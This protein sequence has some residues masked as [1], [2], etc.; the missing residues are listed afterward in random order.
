MVAHLPPD[1][2]PIAKDVIGY[3]SQSVAAN[4]ALA[5]GDSAVALSKFLALPDSACFQGCTMDGLVRVQL[6]EAQGRLAEALEWL[7]AY[8]HGPSPPLPSDVLRALIRGRINERLGNR[9]PAIEAYRSVV[10]T[11]AHADPELQSYVAEARSGL[12]KLGGH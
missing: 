4:L 7:N 6:L 1:V 9:E 10:A 11:W 8:V 3:L 5:Q 12:G 2:P